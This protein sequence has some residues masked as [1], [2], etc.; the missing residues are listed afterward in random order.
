MKVG[1]N[2]LVWMAGAFCVAL[3][4][5]VAVVALFGTN[6]EGFRVA[7]QATA[8][9]NLLLFL[10]A[11][12]G[13]ALTTLFGKAFASLSKNSRNFGLAFAAALSVHLG[14]VACLC[15]A[16]DVPDIK[17]FVIFGAAAALVYLLALLSIPGLRRALPDRFWLIVRAL[18][19]NYIALA[20]IKDFVRPG[21]TSFQNI[22]VLGTGSFQLFIMYAPFIALMILGMMLRFAAWIERARQIDA[23]K[24][25]IR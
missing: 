16:G 15:A 14:L 4:L 13:G 17:T 18:A 8:R 23:G 19:M 3:A 5:A 1:Q 12:V 2:P 6:R 7:L 11:Y 10:P 22:F 20:F 25:Q 21:I 9:F 24:L